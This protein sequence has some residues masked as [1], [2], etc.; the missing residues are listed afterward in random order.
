MGLKIPAQNKGKG[1]SG[2][3]YTTGLV[4]G[5]VEFMGMGREEV[6]EVRVSSRGLIIR[7]V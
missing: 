7:K 5:D 3:N 1:V 2:K 4:Q 6:L